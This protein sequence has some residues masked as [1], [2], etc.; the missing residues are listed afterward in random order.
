MTH[1][2]TCSRP[3]PF[4]AVIVLEDPRLGF[5]GRP[6]IGLVRG[7][8]EVASGAARSDPGLGA[9]GP[10]KTRGGVTARTQ[11]APQA[12]GSYPS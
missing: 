3:F 5:E 8:L 1:F 2:F 6:G 4:I 7:P 10:P 11:K 12:E 9:D